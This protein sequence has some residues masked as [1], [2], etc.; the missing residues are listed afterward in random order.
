MIRFIIRHAKAE[1]GSPSGSDDDRPLSEKGE[2]QAAYLARALGDSDARPT[3]VIC[4]PI[5]RARQT[6]QAIADGLGVG[7]EIEPTLST[8]AYASEA[9][10][11]FDALT[12]DEPIAFVG[13]NPTFSILAG[14]RSGASISLKTGMCAVIEMSGHSRGSLVGVIRM[15][16]DDIS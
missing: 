2:W 7:L 13:H 10:D 15:T 8:H 5:L 9:I 6:A 11:F 12:D 3:R 1:H 4:S 14:E 16:N